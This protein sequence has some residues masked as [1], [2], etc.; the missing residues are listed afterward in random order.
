MKVKTLIMLA[1]LA[2]PGADWPGHAA[3]PLP[4]LGADGAGLTVSGISSGGY[5]AVQFQV[6]FSR[7]VRGA[8]I[9]AAGPYDCA[10]GSSIRALAHCM[11]PSA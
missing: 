4:G 11:S 3:Q 6:A 7:Q 5:M 9:I 1:A 10:E 2:A 8:G